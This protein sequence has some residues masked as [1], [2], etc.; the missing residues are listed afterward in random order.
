MSLCKS[1]WWSVSLNHEKVEGSDKLLCSQVDIGSETRQIVSG[2]SMSYQPEDLV[3]R[4]VIVVTNLAATQDIW[5][6]VTRHA[7]SCYRCGDGQTILNG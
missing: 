3:G 7:A 6:G 5:Q 1:K 4:K 2:I